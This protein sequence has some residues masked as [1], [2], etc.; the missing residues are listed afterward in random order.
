MNHDTENQKHDLE[1]L[2]YR[3][4]PD[5]LLEPTMNRWLQRETGNRL[6]ALKRYNEHESQ[7]SDGARK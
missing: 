6:L 3:R 5:G 1:L 2:P 4:L 7:A